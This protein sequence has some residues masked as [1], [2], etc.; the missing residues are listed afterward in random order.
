MPGKQLDCPVSGMFRGMF[1][2][3]L[4]IEFDVQRCSAAAPACRARP[5]QMVLSPTHGRPARP[6]LQVTDPGHSVLH[7]SKAQPKGQFAFTSKIAG[8]YKACFTTADHT[9]ALSTK[10]SLDWRTGVAAT[11]WDTI[12]KKEH[13]DQ[14]SVEMRKVRSDAP[15]AARQPPGGSQ[16]RAARAG[17]VRPLTLPPAPTGCRAQ[18]E[19]ALREIYAEMLQLQQREQEMR[20]LNGERP[21]QFMQGAARQ[22]PTP[23]VQRGC[24]ARLQQGCRRLPRSPPPVRPPCAPHSRPLAQRRPTRASPGSPSSACWCASPAAWCRCGTSRSSSSVSG[25]G[26]GGGEGGGGTDG[27]R[28]CCAQGPSQH[29]WRYQEFMRRWARHAQSRTACDRPPTHAHTRCLPAG[30]KLL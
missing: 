17:C 11:D 28:A 15:P 26:G 10:I 2:A 1:A 16:Q 22:G 14:L 8:E 20:D 13:L 21:R 7:S 25:R 18:V 6:R 12:A 29:G 5:T 9:T 4:H 19:G 24:G 23:S 30:K 3:A 27:A